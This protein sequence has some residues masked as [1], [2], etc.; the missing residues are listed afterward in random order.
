MFQES[1]EVTGKNLYS[2]RVEE[3]LTSEYEWAALY[4]ILCS[5]FRDYAAMQS[6]YR[7]ATQVW[8]MGLKAISCFG[9]MLITQK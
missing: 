4:C 5:C 9:I 2:L 8:E 7:K 6:V 3:I 1:A